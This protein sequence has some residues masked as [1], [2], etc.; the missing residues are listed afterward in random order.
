VL[1]SALGLAAG[2]TPVPALAQAELA[3]PRPN[4]DEITRLKHAA[5]AAPNDPKAWGDYGRA[6]MARDGLEDRLRASKALRHAVTL[7]PTNVDLRLVLADL[8]FR[9]GYFTLSRRQLLAALKNDKDSAPS[10][11]RLGRLAMRDWRKYQ[12]R[13][14]L[15]A[16]RKYW[17]DAARRAPTD[18]DPWLGLG[19]LALLDRDARGAL[20]AGRQVLAS[21][22]ELPR[23]TQGEALLLVGAGAYG[24][25]WPQIADSAYDAALPRLPA[26]A[27]ALITDITPAA[28]DADTIAYHAILDSGRRAQFL[29]T[30]WK[31]RDPDLTTPYNEVRLE[32]LS[33]GTMAYFL[34]YDARRRAWDER[35]SFLVRYGMPDSVDYNPPPITGEWGSLGASGMNRLMWYYGS[36][37]FTVYFEDRLLNEFYDLPM[38]TSNEV[39]YVPD[40]R[41][42]AE[43]EAEGAATT[44]GRGVF[45][46]ILP[47]EARL[48]GVARVGMFRRVE[49]FDPRAS[50]APASAAAAPLGGFASGNQP[51]ARVEAWLAVTGEDAPRDL[52]GEAVVY[53]DSSFVEVARVRNAIPAICQSDSVGILQFN[54]DLPAGPYVVGLSARDSKREAAGSWRVPI[55][56]FSPAA[57]RLEVSDLELAC[58]VDQGRRDTPFAKTDYEVYPNPLGRAPRDQPFGF[59]FE[60]YN[61]VS[62]AQ[63]K[64]QLSIEYQIRSTRK[65]GRPFF[66]KAVNPRKNDPVVSVSKIDDVP[67]RARFQYVSANLGDQRPGPY[68][69]D[70]TVT[71]L[72]STMVVTK[73]LDFELVE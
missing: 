35:G 27:R 46:T 51:V 68:R 9:Q 36:L 61:L 3:A 16:A 30:F 38:S 47:G 53:R 1:G 22:R 23:Q 15:E 62:D 20:A 8:Y 6:L 41:D 19:V 11:S 10:Y 37:G 29:A 60:V 50:A 12:R 58:G 57:G 18:S 66:I 54:F 26:A 34:Y 7:A 69:V 65:D 48:Q 43:R 14:S 45:R 49:G 32:F 5:E 52:S 40:P 39:D 63:G 2:L 55:F 28:S 73:S 70:V 42:L 72:T 67:G 31:S 71:D 13:G 59:Y 25:G 64:G 56:V 24:L 44:A 21:G 4:V 33:R 17:Q